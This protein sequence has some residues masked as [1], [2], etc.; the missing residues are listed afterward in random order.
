M[1]SFTWEELETFTKPLCSAA[2]YDVKL[3]NAQ[4]VVRSFLAREEY[5][6]GLPVHLHVEATAECNLHCPICPRGR[7]SI[8][9]SGHLPLA[10][11]AHVFDTFSETLSTIVISGWGEPLLNPDTTKMVALATASGVPVF[12][13]TNG[14]VLEDNIGRILD[15]GLRRICVALD[16]AVS[17][18]THAYDDEVPFDKAVRGVELLR[19]AKDKGR[20]EY[21]LIQGL[22]IVT[23]HTADEMEE[24]AKWGYELGVEHVKFK[25]KMR[26]MP[27]Q[28]ERSR[29]TSVEGL[30]AITRRTHVRSNEDLT[31]TAIGCSHPWDSL[32]LD[33]NGHLGLC[34]WDPYQ[35]IDLGVDRGNPDSIWN[36]EQMRRVRRWHSGQDPSVGNPCLT[37]NRLPGYL[38]PGR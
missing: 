14:T 38:V 21:P 27:G 28:I 32:F 8:E 13:N 18:A 4:A 2:Q 11:F 16:G 30:L 29:F 20:Y 15:S 31:F 25:R 10:S 1:L 37:C 5:C 9:R 35:L 3:R 26:T 34:S 33:G 7:G 36:G 12:M 24:L 19:A 22:F 23:E 17:R 6:S